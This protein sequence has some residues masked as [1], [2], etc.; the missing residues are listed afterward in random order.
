[1]MVPIR[2]LIDGALRPGGEA[3][4]LRRSR[5][6][7]AWPGG[8]HSG[9]RA[10]ATPAPHAGHSHPV[11]GRIGIRATRTD[12]TSFRVGVKRAYAASGRGALAPN[13]CDWRN[14]GAQE[15]GS[16]LP[17]SCGGVQRRAQARDLRRT[18]RIDT[19]RRYNPTM[20]RL[21]QGQATVQWPF[22]LF[23]IYAASGTGALPP[24]RQG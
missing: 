6:Q 2:C 9:N 13:A 18:L 19:A 10:G 14:A 20:S 23:A 1:V 7:V 22:A 5:G 3:P 11:S 4:G 16:L 15:R 24:D 12:S 17:R 8:S 21:T